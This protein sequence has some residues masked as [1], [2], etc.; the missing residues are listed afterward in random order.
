MTSKWKG[1]IARLWLVTMLP[2]GIYCIYYT[3]VESPGV[4]RSLEASKDYWLS[5]VEKLHG[6]LP[7]T[8]VN[9]RQMVGDAWKAINEESEHREHMATAAVALLMFPLYAW[10]LDKLLVWIWSGRRQAASRGIGSS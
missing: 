1:R 8:A 10:L 4:I 2:G 9:P 3:A 6:E 7:Q 5:E